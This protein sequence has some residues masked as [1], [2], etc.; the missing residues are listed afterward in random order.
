MLT[1]P[2]GVLDVTA[3]QYAA[4]DDRVVR[5][6]GSVWKPQPYTMKLEGAGAGRYQTLMLVGIQDPDVLSRVDEFHD[7]M[8]AALVSASARDDRSGGR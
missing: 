3:A 1:E 7:K 8:L 5:V 2:G 6:T 4:V